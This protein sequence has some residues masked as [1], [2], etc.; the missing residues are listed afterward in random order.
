ME[1]RIKRCSYNLFILKRSLLLFSQKAT[2]ITKILLQ[3]RH[4]KK[5]KSCFI[6]ASLAQTNLGQN[7]TQYNPI[8]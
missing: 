7:W 2:E 5:Q 3:A 1:E 8:I 4:D 6:D